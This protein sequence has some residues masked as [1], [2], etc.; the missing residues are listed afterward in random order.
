MKINLRNSILCF[1]G[2]LIVL[3]V[4][5]R[6]FG[7]VSFYAV[8]SFGAGYLLGDSLG[9][10]RGKGAGVR[11]ENS[12]IEDEI[13]ERPK[14]EKEHKQFLEDLKERQRK[15]LEEEQINK[16]QSAK[17]GEPIE[18]TGY[19]IIDQDGNDTGKRFIRK[20]DAVKYQDELRGNNKHKGF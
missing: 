4:I 9:F 15:S 16:I 3:V 7:D 14:R 17:T 11:E 8:L 19:G 5:G 13:F 20:E 2:L 6:L 18:L 12:R 1:L 10:R